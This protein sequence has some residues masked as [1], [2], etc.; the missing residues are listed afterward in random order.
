MKSVK[1]VSVLLATLFAIPVF[2]Q[3]T[4]T[5]NIDHRQENQQKRIAQGIN[6]GSLT[7]QEAS[8]LEKREAKIEAD[9]QA[10]KADGKVTKHERQKL[11]HEEDNASK[12]IHA[13][14]HNA[15]TTG[16]AS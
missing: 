11:Q 15:K 9:K 3:T 2:A 12:K 13:K 14:K 1:I 16:S 7:A 5:P 8:H 4:A 6:S 10:A